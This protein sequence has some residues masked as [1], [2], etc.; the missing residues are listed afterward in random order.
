MKKYED[1]RAIKEVRRPKKCPVLNFKPIRE[2]ETYKD[3]LAMGFTERLADNPEGIEVAGTEEQRYF[4]DRLGN[5]AFFHPKLASKPNYPYYNI[6][7]NGSIRVW[8][9]S[10]KSSEYAGLSTD[11][12]RSCMTAE[13]YIF[14]MG[15]LIKLLIQREGFPI[16]DQELMNDE[17]Y[18]DLIRKKM[19][20]DPSRAQKITIP[21]SLKGEDIGKGASLLKRFGGFGED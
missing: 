8:V 18:K 16:T 4:K 12:R 9:G 21:P 11:L 2:S 1:F 20:E 19:E 6:M 5:I 13:D 10:S 7:H 15:F 17:S 3:M 14:K